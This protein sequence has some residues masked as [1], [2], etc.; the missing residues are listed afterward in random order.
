MYIFLI[1]LCEVMH[2][3][4]NVLT[5]I[6]R[7]D[8]IV[9]GHETVFRGAPPSVQTRGP[10]FFVAEKTTKEVIGMVKIN[11]KET[12]LSGITIADYLAQN[13]LAPEK[14]AVMINGEILPKSDY[15]VRKLADGDEVDIVGFVGG[16]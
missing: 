11:G 2:I 14:V 15:S 10:V 3:S 8:I 1:Y 9:D 16:G 7:Y 12:Q 4:S 13:S 5:N 6:F